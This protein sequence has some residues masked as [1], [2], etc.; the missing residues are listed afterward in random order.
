MKNLNLEVIIRKIATLI[1]FIILMFSPF[2]IIE[3]ILYSLRYILYNISFPKQPYCFE[4]FSK[5]W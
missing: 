2:P 4:L 5:M 3:I 1:V